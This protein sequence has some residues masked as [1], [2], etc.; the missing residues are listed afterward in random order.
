MSHTRVTVP[1]SQVTIHAVSHTQPAAPVSQVD[2]PRHVPHSARSSHVPG[3]PSTP[4]PTLSSQLP[5]PRWTFHA[6]SHT[7]LAA[8]TSQVDHPCRVPRSPQLP[9]PRWTIHAVS[10]TQ[11]VAPASQV[12]RPRHVP[13][14]GHSSRVPGDRLRHV[15]HSG[16]SSRVPGGPSTPYRSTPTPANPSRGRAGAATSFS[17]EP[18]GGLRGWTPGSTPAL[19]PRPG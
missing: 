16:H 15:P 17:Q 12:D 4:C 14:S 5:R 3:G 6:M 18:L 2:Y 9:R 11:P 19:S 1:A 10:H 13:H 7:L 8:P